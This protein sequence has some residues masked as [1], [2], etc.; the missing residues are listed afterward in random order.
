MAKALIN[1]IQAFIEQSIKT[2]DNDN[3]FLV[4]NELDIIIDEMIVE[5]E[6]QDKDTPD[7]DDDDDDYYG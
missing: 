7:D 5:I 4:L 2:L 1:K 3:K 6:N